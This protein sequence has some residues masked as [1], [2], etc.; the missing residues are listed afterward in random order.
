MENLYTAD[1]AEV[2]SDDVRQAVAEGRA[3]IV[4]S[5]GEWRNIG[6]LQIYDTE[7]EASIEA[8]RDTRDECW[9]MADELWGELATDDDR[10]LRAAKGLLAVS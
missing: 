8:R 1:G 4:W 7:A 5:H 6:R 2:T 9:S 3:V 10:A